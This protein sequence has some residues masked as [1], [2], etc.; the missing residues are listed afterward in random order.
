MNMDFYFILAGRTDE[1]SRAVR[2]RSILEENGLFISATLIIGLIWL[3][4]YV[5]ENLQLRRKADAD[6]P[7]GLFY[8]LCKSHR[9]SRTDIN[10][11]LKAASENYGDQPA[12][13]FIDPEIL[14]AYSDITSFSPSGCFKS[15]AELLQKS[16]LITDCQRFPAHFSIQPALSPHKNS[17]AC[18]V[19]VGELRRFRTRSL[20][21]FDRSFLPP[22]P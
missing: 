19:A 10:Y 8:D 13:I 14:D 12:M 17:S 6:T 3:T 5:W 18:R 1:I 11:L 22:I 7:Q 2:N 21:M 9:L 20:L 4:L 15:N 16:R